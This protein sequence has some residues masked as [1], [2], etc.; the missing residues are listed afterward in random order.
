M[1]VFIWQVYIYQIDDGYLILT[2]D[3]DQVASISV[4]SKE[5]EWLYLKGISPISFSY[6]INYKDLTLERMESLY[7][8][9]W[10]DTGSGISLTSYITDKGKIIYFSFQNGILIG[11]GEIDIITKDRKKIYLRGI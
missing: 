8:S 3:Y 10:F 6:D 7:G 9:E 11:I 4:L 5:K 2:I 1:M